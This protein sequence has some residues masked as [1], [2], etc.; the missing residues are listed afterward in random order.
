MDISN[1]ETKICYD[2]AWNIID[3]IVKDIVNLSNIHA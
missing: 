3:D 2:S 1:K